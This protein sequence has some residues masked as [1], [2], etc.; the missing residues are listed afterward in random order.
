MNLPAPEWLTKDVMLGLKGYYKM[1][2]D[3]E[4]ARP[5]LKRLN[6]GAIVK[7]LLRNI[8][9]NDIRDID[10]KIYLYSV[11]DSHVGGLART[12]KIPDHQVP[13]Y[14]STIVLEKLRS[15]LG[16]EYVRV[17]FEKSI[18]NTNKDLQKIMLPLFQ[19][20]LGR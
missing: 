1:Y 10:R 13:V 8:K 3:F 16:N 2:M 14:G 18:K 17:S 15:N 5:I 4:S 12:L 19:Y 11:H 6:A 9:R 7:K 20:I